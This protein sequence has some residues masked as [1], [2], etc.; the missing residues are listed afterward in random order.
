MVENLFSECFT[1]KKSNIKVKTIQKYANQC[2]KITW[3]CDEIKMI[4]KGDYL[5]NCPCFQK[6]VYN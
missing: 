5:S 4:S 3:G 2:D 1:Q 6:I